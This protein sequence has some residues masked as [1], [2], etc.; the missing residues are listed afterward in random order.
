MLKN[1][2]C[3]EADRV[4]PRSA[5][6]QP[7]SRQLSV[8]IRALLSGNARMNRT[9]HFLAVDHIKQQALLFARDL[10]SLSKYMATEQ[11]VFRVLNHIRSTA[12]PPIVWFVGVSHGPRRHPWDEQQLPFSTKAWIVIPTGNAV[13]ARE[14]VR[15][16]FRCGFAAS[17]VHSSSA[18]AMC[19]FAYALNTE[20]L[21]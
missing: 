7:Q 10:T 8:S 12:L 15:E 2:L 18:S 21:N 16:L 9:A 20:I 11:I 17:P 13:Q 1:H 5:N 3:E 6:D 19:V 14:V 4:L